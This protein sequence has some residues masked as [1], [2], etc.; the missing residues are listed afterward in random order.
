M[1]R[2]LPY[3]LVL[4]GIVAL[5][6]VAC[7]TPVPTPTA[8]PVPTAV[9]TA[10]P[11]P[12]PAATP[13]PTE[14]PKP[15]Q[16]AA[17]E[18]RFAT[19]CRGCHGNGLAAVNLN[20]Y[21]TAGGLHDYI[22]A[23]MPPGNPNAISEQGRYDLVAYLLAKAGLMPAA[24]V[25]NADTLAKIAWAEPTA[26]A[27]ETQLASGETTFGVSCA[28]C[29]RAGFAESALRRYRTAAALF[30]FIH[31]SMPPGN[32]DL[33]PEKKAYDIVA[34]ILSKAGLIKADQPVNAD[35]ASTLSFE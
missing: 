2:E 31:S 26:P 18:Q 29:H 8:T 34:Y 9:P 1:R 4:L 6:L 32:P 22:K 17:G 35:T 21:K 30:Q 16:V 25:V 5:V 12:P 28:G 20:S 7:A 13:K 27:G 19:Y 3:H 24:Q 10:T 23:R 33:I 11:V 14:P 15:D